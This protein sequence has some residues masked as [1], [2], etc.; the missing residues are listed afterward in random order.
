MIDDIVQVGILFK[1]VTSAIRYDPPVDDMHFANRPD[2]EPLFGE[3]LFQE[4]VV[5]DLNVS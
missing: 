4:G 3:Q 1:M 2:I 5:T